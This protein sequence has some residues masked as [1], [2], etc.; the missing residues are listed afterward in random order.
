MSLT[1]RIIRLKCDI[2]DCNIVDKLTG[3]EPFIYSG[4]DIEFQLGIFDHGS[5]AD[6]SSLTSV[7]LEIR[8]TA[9]AASYYFQGTDSSL[10]AL[11][12]ATW[13]DDTA[14]HAAI[15]L[16]HAANSLSGGNFALLIYGYTATTRVVLASASI[17][18]IETV[19]GGTPTVTAS[20]YSKTEVDSLI[21]GMSTYESPLT[22]KGD[23]LTYSTTD[24]RLGVGTDGYVLTADS[25]AT[26]G[27]K[28]AAGVPLAAAS[29][30]YPKLYGVTSA[31]EVTSSTALYYYTIAGSSGVK[32]VYLVGSLSFDMSSGFTTGEYLRIT[33]VPWSTSGLAIT[34]PT[35]TTTAGQN[36]V[37]YASGGAYWDLKYSPTTGYGF[38]AATKSGLSLSSNLLYLTV[39]GMDLG[40]FS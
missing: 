2:A 6:V 30:F 20:Y 31:T 40:L 15:S 34:L 10:S 12:L 18:V 5:L 14:Q 9:D 21:A 1:T 28:W 37:L 19:L 11:T 35:K 23:L 36:L 16:A 24:A 26:T 32:L 22:T 8:D 25:T 13:D 38:S 33:S 17:R 27:I 39:N 3:E 29:S 7:V 4:E